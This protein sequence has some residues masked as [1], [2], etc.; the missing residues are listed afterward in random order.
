MIF[1]LPC[2]LDHLLDDMARRRLVRVAHSKI[3]DVFTLL[4]SLEF[5]T[6]HLGKYIWG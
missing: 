6:L 5:E 3:D 1:S 4:A 2:R